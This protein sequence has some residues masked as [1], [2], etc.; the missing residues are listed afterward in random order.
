M[1]SNNLNLFEIPGQQK[2]KNTPVNNLV[3]SNNKSNI[4]LNRTIEDIKIGSIDSL[5][6][7]NNSMLLEGYT[8]KPLQELINLYSSNGFSGENFKLANI[9]DH[10]RSES[11]AQ[12]ESILRN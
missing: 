8:I 4:V 9:I 1:I 2:S 3:T 6:L 12:I 7:A 5:K 11:I 10:L